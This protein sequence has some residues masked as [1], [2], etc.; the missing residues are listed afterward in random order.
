MHELSR[1]E[2]LLHNR[3]ERVAYKTTMGMICGSTHRLQARPL[4]ADFGENLQQLQFL[5]LASNELTVLPESLVVM[6]RL[7]EMNLLKTDS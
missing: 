6:T 1:R 2:R 7:R 5:S 3:Q 4:P